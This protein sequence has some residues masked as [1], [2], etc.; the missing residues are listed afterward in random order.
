MIVGLVLTSVI[1]IIL[2]TL[3]L[4]YAFQSVKLSVS[5]IVTNMA[6]QL[7]LSLKTFT[8]QQTIARLI[9]ST[10]GDSSL[11]PVQ[12][13]GDNYFQIAIQDKPSA[14]QQG[15]IY[16]LNYMALFQASL[17][18]PMIIDNSFE[19]FL[20]AVNLAYNRNLKATL[21]FSLS[22]FGSNEY[23]VMSTVPVY[24]KGQ[25]TIY[26]WPPVAYNMINKQI[27]ANT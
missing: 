24:D 3:L 18:L 13:V 27:A 11:I 2:I 26:A 20:S 22:T 25:A 9:T 5:Q 19:V 4:A 15:D 16:S 23:L 10:L 12:S 17:N 6:N 1:L 8:T 21:M 7:S 14:F